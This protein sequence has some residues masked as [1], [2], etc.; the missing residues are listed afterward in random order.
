MEK[1]RVAIVDYDMGNV[2]SVANA[3]E[4]L[5]CDVVITSRKNELDDADSIILPG[6]GAFGE[7]IKHLDQMK[8]IPVLEDQVLKKKKRFLGICLGM[9]LLA[10]EG[11]E[12]GHHKGLG[13]IPGKVCKLEVGDLRL[14][15]V[16]WNNLQAVRAEPLFEGMRQDPDFYF[17][18]SFHF[19]CEDKS[20]IVA[21][22]DYGQEFTSVVGKEN[23]WGVQFH[24]EKSQKMGQK[25]LENFLKS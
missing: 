18:H 17:V 8:L 4:N 10:E 11:F 15:H 21:T 19:V 3:F 6:V 16:G 23:I 14:P 2:Q 22:T 25:L 7:G 9:Q 1:N 13:W 5:G 24:P 20:H 12:F